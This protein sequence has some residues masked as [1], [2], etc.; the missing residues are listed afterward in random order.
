MASASACR[1]SRSRISWSRRRRSCCSR[2][3]STSTASLH[4]FW[5]VSAS[6]TRSARKRSSSRNAWSHFAWALSR[7]NNAFSAFSFAS[8]PL[9]AT[10]SSRCAYDASCFSMP[11]MTRSMP[12]LSPLTCSRA[13]SALRAFSASRSPLWV[14]VAR[15]VWSSRARAPAAWTR[16]Q[17]SSPSA[18]SRSV[19]S[20]HV[21]VFSSS[22]SLR[23]EFWACNCVRPSF[24]S[25]SCAW[26]CAMSV[27]C[28]TY[29]SSRRRRA[30]RHWPSPPSKAR[31]FSVARSASSRKDAASFVLLSK[32][33]EHRSNSA[34][35]TAVC[36]TMSAFS[37][38][39]MSTRS[40][41]S[42]ARSWDGP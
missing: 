8:R 27:E 31:H 6:W 11:L 17:S 23:V 32:S 30:S 41:S 4:L 14:C 38:M 9:C 10:P 19:R 22:C 1:S 13:R 39:R 42:L 21:R 25:A 35:S 18:S 7:A 5:N 28:C 40:A 36:S 29:L 34:W 16:C 26:A 15:D 12:A 3:A 37:A 33:V 24:N 2:R 20:A